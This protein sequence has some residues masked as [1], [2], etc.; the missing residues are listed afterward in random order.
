MTYISVSIKPDATRLRCSERSLIFKRK[1]KRHKLV[2]VFT[3][4][5]IET[6][7]NHYLGDEWE[8]IDLQKGRKIAI[9]ARDDR[10]FWQEL[11]PKL[12]DIKKVFSGE[13]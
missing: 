3:V 13:I 8:I 1:A 2:G 5:Q 10:P 11:H 12:G 4:S 9:N 7:L 6:I